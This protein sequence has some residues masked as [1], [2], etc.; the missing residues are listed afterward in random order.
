MQDWIVKQFRQEI[1]EMRK[2]VRAYDSELKRGQFPIP[3]G[4]DQTR[5]AKSRIESWIAEREEIIR[6]HEATN[7]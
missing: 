6:Q 3:G 7:A 2:W 5:E 4:E 1:E